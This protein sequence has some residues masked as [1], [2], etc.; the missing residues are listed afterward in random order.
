[1]YVAKSSDGISTI[2]CWTVT[3]LISPP[4]NVNAFHNSLPLLV[5]AADM[6]AGKQVVRFWYWLRYDD[7][8]VPLVLVEIFYHWYWLRVATLFTSGLSLLT[9]PA[10]LDVRSSQQAAW[11]RSDSGRQGTSPAPSYSSSSLSWSSRRV[12]EGGGYPA[13]PIPPRPLDFPRPQPQ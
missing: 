5:H 6:W 12:Q 3:V 11:H 9:T 4:G 7:Q 1:M 10:D 8:R 13:C 2:W